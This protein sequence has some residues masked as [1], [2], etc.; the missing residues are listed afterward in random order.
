MGLPGWSGLEDD[1]EATMLQ[2][3]DDVPESLQQSEDEMA[4]GEQVPYTMLAQ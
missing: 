4:D 2:M 3:E 1:D